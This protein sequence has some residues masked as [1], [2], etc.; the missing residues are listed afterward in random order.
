[1]GG[2]RAVCCNTMNEQEWNLGDWQRDTW[3]IL[4]GLTYL[5]VV[6]KPSLSFNTTAGTWLYSTQTPW[7]AHAALVTDSQ[8]TSGSHFIQNVWRTSHVSHATPAALSMAKNFYVLTVN[9][10]TSSYKLAV[11]LSWIIP[12]S[13]C[14]LVRA[15]SRWRVNLHDSVRPLSPLK[16][17]LPAQNWLMQYSYSVLGL[18]A[19]PRL[20]IQ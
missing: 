2:R 17:C 7:N 19:T 16:W 11:S 4:C 18:P 3:N 5:V 9:N 20:L 13:Y 10:P 8:N 6:V 14:V 12:Y 15:P 1:M